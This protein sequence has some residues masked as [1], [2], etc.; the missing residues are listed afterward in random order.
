MQCSRN[1]AH[2]LKTVLGQRHQ[3][4][5][6]RSKKLYLNVCLRKALIQLTCSAV[7]S[8]H[9][10]VIALVILASIMVLKTVLGWEIGKP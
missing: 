9:Q 6:R 4:G 8:P 3:P 5:L 10:A 2:S 1:D 7:G